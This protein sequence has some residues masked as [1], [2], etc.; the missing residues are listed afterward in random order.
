[1]I[2]YLIYREKLLNNQQINLIKLNQACQEIQESISMDLDGI[3]KISLIY[4]LLLMGEMDKKVKMAK[5][6]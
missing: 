5:M 6:E 4:I 3:L 1:M 2:E